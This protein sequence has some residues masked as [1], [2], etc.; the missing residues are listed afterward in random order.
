MS[1]KEKLKLN[2]IDGAK[3][4]NI[5]AIVLSV[6]LLPILLI[7]CILLIESMVK[8]NEVPSI[9]K[10]TPL[11]VLTESM[12]PEIKAGDLIICENI[13]AGNVKEGDVISFFDPEGNGSSVVTHRVIGLVHEDGALVGFRTQGDNNDI[14]D[15]LTVPV[16]NLVGIWTGKRV[17]GIGRVIL[18]TQSTV[19]IILCLVLPIGAFVLYEVLRRKKQD[20]EKQNDI[21]A[22]RA[23]L[24]ALKSGKSNQEDAQI[25]AAVSDTEEVSE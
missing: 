6:L 20:Q 13:K 11:I 21:D 7:N 3:A 8:P 25:V 14:E 10:M 18:F 19:G 9:G 17:G 2:K 5:A 16:E 23:E 1:I 22:L 4:L 24:E 15:R 12:E